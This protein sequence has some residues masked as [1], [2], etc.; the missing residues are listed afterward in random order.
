MKNRYKRLF[1]WVLA[2]GM[3]L[4]NGAVPDLGQTQVMASEVTE[5]TPVDGDGSGG[6]QGSAASVPVPA[7]VP[8]VSETQ[9]A[10]IIFDVSD[11]RTSL[12]STY[13][14]KTGDIEIKY[15]VGDA[16]G[17]TLDVEQSV[18]VTGDESGQITVRYTESAALLYY[19]VANIGNYKVADDQGQTYIKAPDSLQNTQPYTISVDITSSSISPASGQVLITGNDTFE[20]ETTPI[21]NV[22][23]PNAVESVKFSYFWSVTDVDG[24]AEISGNN[25]AYS[26]QLTPQKAGAVNL[27]VEIH[28]ENNLVGT[29]SI[30]LTIKKVGRLITLQYEPEEDEQSWNTPLTLTATVSDNKFE[31]GETVYFYDGVSTEPIGK[32]QLDTDGKATLMWTPTQ[33]GTYSLKAEIG[34]STSGKYD[35]AESEPKN[36]NPAAVQG[37]FEVKLNTEKPEVTYGNDEQIATISNITGSGNFSVVLSEESEENGTFRFGS[38]DSN[39]DIPLYWKPDKTGNVKFT[40]KQEA[41]NDYTEFSSAEINVVSKQRTVTISSVEAKDRTYDGSDSIDLTITLNGVVSMDGDNGNST[42][43]T[44]K[45]QGTVADPN[46]EKEK[47]VSAE[48][49]INTFISDFGS[50]YQLSYNDNPVE[51]ASEVSVATTVNINQAVLKL[52][53]PNGTMEW[54]KT[55][56]I[57]NVTFSPD[58]KIIVTGFVNGENTDNLAGFSVPDLD[59]D[60]SVFVNQTD[61]VVEN[62]IV[63]KEQTGNPTNNY[64]FDFEN[65]DKKGTLT[66]TPETVNDYTKFITVDNSSCTN[67]YRDEEKGTIYY[68]VQ[69]DD[70]NQTINPKIVFGQENSNYSKICSNDVDVTTEGLTITFQPTDETGRTIEIWLE[71]DTPYKRT[72]SF[73]I[74]LMR[75]QNAPSAQIQI[76][77]SKSLWQNFLQ[78]VTFGVFGKSLQA[79][80]T[81]SDSGDISSGLKSWSYAV[82]NTAS[83]VLFDELPTTEEDVK[84]LF[85]NLNFTPVAPERTTQTVNLNGDGN[86]IVFVFVTDNAGNSA[87]YGS[88]GAIV[89]NIQTGSISITDEQSGD[90]SV[91]DYYKGNVSLNVT[92]DEAVSDIYSGVAKAGYSITSET[93]YSVSTNDKE[94]SE[95][96]FIDRTEKIPNST[97][98]VLKETY[99]T[100]SDVLNIG[101]G[102]G[103]SSKFTVTINAEDFAG[104]S[105]ASDTNNQVSFV[106]DMKAPVVVNTLSSMAQVQNGSFYNQ[107]V[108]LTT[109][110]TERFLDK[111]GIGYTIN[112]ISY[113]LT[114]LE[115]T[116]VQSALGLT[117]VNIGEMPGENATDEA[118]T[119]ITLTFNADNDYEIITK[120]GDKAGNLALNEDGERAD[121]EAI[122]FTIDKTEPQVSIQYYNE[123]GGEITEDVAAACQTTDGRYYST[124]PAYALV[125]ITEHNFEERDISTEYT[126]GLALNFTAQDSGGN[127]AEGVAI[128]RKWESVEE[129]KP[130]EHILRVDFT[131]NANYTVSFTYTD[132]AGNDITDYS[133]YNITVDQDENPEASIQIDTSPDNVWKNIID[134]ITFGI[135]SNKDQTVTIE[136]TDITSGIRSIH[137]LVDSNSEIQAMIAMDEDDLKDSWTNEKDNWV[138]SNQVT[139]SPDQQTVIYGRIEDKAG[140]CVFISTDGIVLETV[141]PS[142]VTLSIA[143]DDQT[144]IY[145]NDVTVHVSV[146]NEAQIYSGIE[147]ITAKAYV[148]GVEVE[149]AVEGNY[150]GIQGQRTEDQL[151]NDAAAEVD[152]KV[153]AE[154]CNIKTGNGDSNNVE[155]VVTVKD[156]AGNEMTDD[157]DFIIDQNTPDVEVAFSPSDPVHSYDGVHYFDSVRTATVTVT[158]ANFNEN[159]VNVAINTMEGVTVSEWTHNGSVHTK[160]YTF[161]ADCDYTFNVTMSDMAGN[162]GAMRRDAPSWDKAFTIDLTDP[163]V[164]SV[165]YYMTVNGSDEPVAPG[166][167]ERERLYG[168]HPVYAVI[169]VIEH[170]FIVSDDQ[171]DGGLALNITADS[172]GAEYTAPL[173]SWLS[174]DGDR[175]VLKVEFNGDANYVFDI[176]YTD[177]AKRGLAQDYAS[178]YFTV[179]TVA[180]TANIQ[181]SASTD[182]WDK[183][184][185]D[186]LEKITFGI[187]SNKDETVSITDINDVT[188]GVAF[189]HYLVSH[190]EMTWDELEESW[191]AE[192]NNWLSGSQV[193]LSP[194][195]QAVVYG[196]IEDKSGNYMYLNTNGFV[197]DDTDVEIEITTPQP[198]DYVYNSDVDVAV[199]VKDPDPANNH[200]Y[201]GLASVYY[202]VRNTGNVTQSGNIPVMAGETR[203]KSVTQTITVDAALNNSNDVQ[204]YVRAVDNAGNT[205]EATLS[206]PM[207]ID[208]TQPQITV[209]FD[210]NAPL[211]GQYYQDTRTATVTVRERNFDPNNVQ[212]N[213]T[214]T[215]GTQPAITGWSSSANAGVSDEATHT[216]Q[217]IFAADGD[218]TFTV[219]CTDL[220]LNPAS[221]PYQSEQFTIDKTLPTVSVS[222]NNAVTNGH[223]YNEGRTA[224]ITITE[225]NFRA[226][227]ARATITAALDGAGI[228]APSI[229]GWSTSGD[230]H[231]ATV[232]FDSDGDYTFDIAY[233]DLAGNVMADYT[234]DSFTVDLTDPEVEIT[235]VENRSANK[236]TVAPVITLTD[237]NYT[238]DGVS[239][240]LTGTNKGRLNVDSMIS[241]S[242]VNNGQVITFR[243]FG[244][245]MDD[246]YTLTARLTDQAGN[247]TTRSITFSVN[248]DGSTYE[249]SDYTQNLIE[250]RFAN[251]PQDIVIRETNVDTLEFIEITYSKDGQVVTLK[252]GVDYTVEEEGGDGQ[253]K[254]YTYTIK[255]SCFEEEGEYSITI[256]S[257]DRARNT[258]TNRVK[259]KT[260]EFV[261]D[262]TAPSVS[263][264]NLEDRGRYRENAHEFTLSVKDNTVLSYVE[265]YLDGELV[266]TYSGDEL[267]IE[268][269]VLTI[270]VDSKNAYQTVRI[271]AYDAAGNPTD[272]VE[273]QVLVTSNWWIQFYMNKPLFFGCIAVM[274]A[275]AG[276]IIFVIVRRGRKKKD[277]YKKI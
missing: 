243:N 260:I 69:T 201:S 76:G 93:P 26:V 111:S 52:S 135:F 43:K 234:Q 203:Q 247:E 178:D 211:N 274:A 94:A 24:E 200:D 157:I 136:G 197:L 187:F 229:S 101:I 180:P 133:L 86:Y 206:Q 73:T 12:E 38:P 89:D 189:V 16:S 172:Q 213:I 222:Y 18:T 219:G 216:C 137:Y 107:P 154:K 88:N 139:I 140:N 63:A 106:I 176:A 5:Q 92:I 226:A 70:G 254:V 208:I 45:V 23:V 60:T 209:S 59:L 123:S 237:V 64:V 262:K 82:A 103:I 163:V 276:W 85:A 8:E 81:V 269:G 152:F 11:L 192:D 184:W 170:N 188:A 143:G 90:Y 164:E 248:R 46:A 245:D 28:N 263:I 207:A 62:A 149:G 116:S 10:D 75:D 31:S 141:K 256:Y 27:S 185:G 159:L 240:T 114:Q 7:N 250:T 186:L 44:I 87:L 267:T 113:S 34:E 150:A 183:F 147:S 212:I 83:D 193:R 270:T 25:N 77:E 74:S 127:E 230:R 61:G 128:T 227:E 232:Y 47:A 205:S 238:A 105:L 194:D 118:T 228:S 166:K 241:R 48:F 100:Y 108:T 117:A 144:G 266:H 72:E 173:Y 217:I 51:N 17:S 21:F 6:D 271:I 115:D 131:E 210:N 95:G 67:V 119:V 2:V 221:N 55:T 79:D 132:K 225:H 261:V 78:N 96:V 273:Y 91:K 112:G 120:V 29:D 252:E 195:Q 32:G 142:P 41:T 258:S 145:N 148:D 14:I 264:A 218:Y 156:R 175:H 13:G 50:K 268:D 162:N 181:I 1:A 253:W 129:S 242:A 251:S 37:S 155:V 168:D 39:G 196:R 134:T 177:L 244:S 182:S 215:D 84:N 202:E 58:E 236:G 220:A 104:N 80:I 275:A 97:L 49:D 257:E 165:Q 233:T 153:F 57:N 190:D 35:K 179:D 246:I 223:Y 124:V 71:G 99:G 204:V 171:G 68:S 53:I 191:K 3:V 54:Q 56:D 40:I 235:G 265:L 231:T 125:T 20:L 122:Q 126:G 4:G 199:Y 65:Y 130:D 214:N 121:S 151:K 259:E 239:L 30:G 138:E 160:T 174:H 42:T 224:T 109:T 102:K 15:Y 158:E 249:L 198:L 167:A 36:Y 33:M 66:L 98:G 22:S 255:A 272:P 146:K 277:H 169:T 9:T 19:K 161:E 110:I